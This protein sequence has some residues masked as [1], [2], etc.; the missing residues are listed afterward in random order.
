MGRIVP[1]ESLA[2]VFLSDSPSVGRTYILEFS[3]KPSL[4]PSTDKVF[5]K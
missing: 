1:L 4:G 5:T 2:Y 3:T